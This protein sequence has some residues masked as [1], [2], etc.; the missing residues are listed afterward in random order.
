MKINPSLREGKGWVLNRMRHSFYL[1]DSFVQ[2]KME[3][4]PEGKVNQQDDRDVQIISEEE[5]KHD[6]KHIHQNDGGQHPAHLHARAQQLMMDMVPVRL[7]W[8]AVLADTMQGHTDNIE[9]RN[10]QRTDGNKDK[11]GMTLVFITRQHDAQQ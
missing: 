9:E 8:I 6:V 7:K 2:T 1:F 11:T 5:V 3:N 10:E 4:T